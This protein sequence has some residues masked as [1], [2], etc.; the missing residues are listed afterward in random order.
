MFLKNPFVFAILTEQGNG[1]I[2]QQG[3]YYLEEKLIH[4]NDNINI[5]I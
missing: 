3:F 5:K 1:E 2:Y 4:F